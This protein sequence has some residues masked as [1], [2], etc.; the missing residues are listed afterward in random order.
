MCMEHI[1]RKLAE[2]KAHNALRRL[3]VRDFAVDFYSNDYIGF[4]ASD[5]LRG[6]SSMILEGYKQAN[7]ATGSR[8]LS[9]N[10]PIFEDTEAYIAGAHKAEAALLYNSGYDAN[11]GFFSCILQR[12]DVLLYDSYS[13]ASIRDGISLSQA[14]SYKFRHNDLDHLEALL[15]KFAGGGKSVLIATES[16]F[17]MDGDSPDLL[18]MCELASQYGAHI[19]IDEAHAIGVF[20]ENGSGLVQAL[21]LEDRVLARIVTFGKGLGAHGAAVVSTKEVKEYL[22]NFSRSFI[23][24]T[25]MAPHAVA[26]ILAGYQ[27]LRTTTASEALKGNIHYFKSELEKRQLPRF[28][29]SE[30]AIQA[31]VL[32][33]NDYVKG[34]ATQLQAKGLGVLPILSPTVPKGE[35]RLRVCLHSYNTMQEIDLLIDTLSK[36]V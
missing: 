15:Q 27:L 1:S 35:E 28:I 7:G 6:L 12:G 17:S 33:G 26:T 30:S 8:L 36:A 24:T 10:A 23:Y 22:V 34:V 4:S 3:Q 20:G 25:A 29:P 16:V 13:H 32:S 9:G 19:A 5:E 2:R 11:V 18:R 31:V 21:G 14:Q